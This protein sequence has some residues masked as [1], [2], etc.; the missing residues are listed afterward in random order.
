MRGVGRDEGRD[1]PGGAATSPSGDPQVA[2]NR[3][4]GWT[5]DPQRAHAGPEPGA[6]SRRPQWGQYG[7]VP[8]I[9]PLQ[10]GQVRSGAAAAPPRSG[11]GF[12]VSGA[13]A[14]ASPGTGVGTA[15]FAAAAM[16]RGLP[17][18]IQKRAPGSLARPQ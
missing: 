6:E 11:A 17:Q 9:L 1:R 16:E 8:S 10:N 13:G 14:V 15:F 3:V 2:Q 4:P 7:N 18:S 12:T 5:V